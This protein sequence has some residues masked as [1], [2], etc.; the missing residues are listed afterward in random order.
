MQEVMEK[1]GPIHVA[2][3]RQVG[4]TDEE[5]LHRMSLDYW[6]QREIPMPDYL[7]GEWLTTTSRTLI[8]GPTGLGK[9]NF[10]VG[11][12]FA[13]AQGSD[14]LH[15]SGNGEPHRVLYVDGEMSKQLMQQRLR[16]GLRRTGIS[17]PPGLY[18][19]NRED[20]ED[21]PGLN[22]P[23]GQA[24]MNRQIKIVKPH[25][26]IFD[27]VMS[28]LEGNMTDE[29]AWSETMP[30]V[31]TLTRQ[32]IGQI[33]FHHTGHNEKH[34]YGTKTREW[35]MDNVIMMKKEGVDDTDI[36]FRLEFTKNRTKTP[37]NWE[38]FTTAS[39]ALQADAWKSTTISKTPA[40]NTKAA[41]EALVLL[42]GPDKESVA[43]EEWRAGFG[44][45]PRMEGKTEQAWKKAFQRAAK[46]LERAGIVR[47]EGGIVSLI[48]D[49]KPEPSTALA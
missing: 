38:D 19:I 29:E 46:S 35:P 7:M 21:M 18:V 41:R 17:N 34:S 9:T 16:D 22:K 43:V 14:F 12:A 36:F 49:P 13:S 47:V 5:L 44:V 4:P 25:L 42:L 28:L 26:I 1:V 2:Q 6:L 30:W 20:F 8:V 32:R 40:G 48:P 11:L 23:E 37:D 10:G 27:N 31:K 15:W 39:V 24:F 3:P 33:W 45:H